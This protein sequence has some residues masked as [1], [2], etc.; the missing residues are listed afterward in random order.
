MSQ[1]REDLWTLLPEGPFLS[2]S[3][4]NYSHHFFLASFLALT[5]NLRLSASFLRLCLSFEQKFNEK[6]LRQ[7][8]V[9][10]KAVVHET[11]ATHASV[12]FTL[13]A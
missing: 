13:Q 12:Q 11:S 10:G 7:W 3:S 6:G 4:V 2:L 9:S 1:R 5:L 8:L